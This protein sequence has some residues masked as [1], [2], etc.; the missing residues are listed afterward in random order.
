MENKFYAPVDLRCRQAMI[1][2]LQGHLRYFTMNSWNGT[3]SFANN[4]KLHRLGL[5]S[6]VYDKAYDVLEERDWHRQLGRRLYRFSLEHSGYKV[7]Q[8]GRSGGYLVLY[9]EKHAGEF[10]DLGDLE[11]RYYWE[12]GRLQSVTCLVQDF[13]QLCDELREDLIAYCRFTETLLRRLG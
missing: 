12:H 8:N 5:P 10:T 11:D 4:V 3:K 9:S 6:D 13:D 2:F 7:Y 1:D